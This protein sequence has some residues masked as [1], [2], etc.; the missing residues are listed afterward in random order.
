MEDRKVV[1]K[2]TVKE[3]FKEAGEHIDNALANVMDQ[4]DQNPL[5][6]AFIQ[7]LHSL[8]NMHQF[9]YDN[10]ENFLEDDELPVYA[11]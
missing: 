7:Q 2:V 8:G 6:D 11:A 1:G 4:A 9:I 5:V 10:F 3:L